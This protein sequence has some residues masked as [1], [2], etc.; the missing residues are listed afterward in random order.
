M[1]LISRSTVLNS[2]SGLCFRLFP[3]RQS[4]GK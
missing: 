3:R 2:G 1:T 4:C